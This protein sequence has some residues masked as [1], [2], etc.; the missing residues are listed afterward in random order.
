MA[1]G[2]PAQ[3]SASSQIGASSDPKT[4]GTQTSKW[5]GGSYSWCA[6]NND[7]SLTLT[8]T[9]P[10]GNHDVFIVWDQ[11]GTDGSFAGPT[12][13]EIV[14]DPDDPARDQLSTDIASYISGH[15]VNIFPQK[16]KTGDRATIAPGQSVKVTSPD[17]SKLGV[18]IA[19][20]LYATAV[21][22][23]IL[24][25]TNQIAEELLSEDINA[26][27]DSIACVNYLR[28]QLYKSGQPDPPT[29][30]WSAYAESTAATACHNAVA[31]I[32]HHE[33]KKAEPETET[34]VESGTETVSHD[35][36]SDIGDIGDFITALL[37][38]LDDS[39]DR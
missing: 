18:Y 19:H 24:G 26:E 17:G 22:T 8:N 16:A 27:Q 21:D 10:Q 25:L 34:E 6:Y 38:D 2:P 4:C 35:A 23:V 13:H 36:Y 12:G 5:N 14:T 29:D 39:G 9:S 15:V 3:I 32:F 20:D 30:I 1:C 37:H 28:G 7:T 33:S 31:Y 11:S